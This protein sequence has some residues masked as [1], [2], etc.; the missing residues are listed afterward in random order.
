M[1]DR[2]KLD[3]L[4]KGLQRNKALA[5]FG[6]L[7][8]GAETVLRV[9]YFAKM[10]VGWRVVSLFG[11]AF[12]YKNIFTAYNSYTYGPVVSAYFRKNLALAKADKFEITDR[13]REFFEIDTSQY[14]NYDFHD[15]GHDYH[16]HHGP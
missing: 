8:L 15:L 3:R 10:A 14:M 16:A 2:D 12:L 1:Q 6:G 5:W 9:P 4:Y 13:K 7:W 11:A